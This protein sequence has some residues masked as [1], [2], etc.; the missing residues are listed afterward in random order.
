M[1]RE[2]HNE[3]PKTAAELMAEL[4][5][6]PQYVARM[7]AM[8]EERANAVEQRLRNAKPIVTDL[9]SAGFTVESVSD[10]FHL[11]MDYQKAIPI[12]L[13]WLPRLNDIA[14]KQDV[15]RALTV[16]WAKPTA[17]VPLIEEFRRA[18]G[19]S[20]E[21]LRWAIANALSVVA[22]DS[23]YG[24]VAQLAINPTNGKPREM[25][26]LALGNMENPQAVPVLTEL[27]K[28]DQVIGHAVMALGA[29]KAK[30]SRA[31]IQKHANHTKPWIRK[32][33]AAALAQIDD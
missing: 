16:L 31:E 11:K 22:D 30:S 25:L 7:K 3:L 14:V 20:N 29:L 15:I 6:D 24:D 4:S 2:F 13:A 28:D 33:V 23:V 10:L 32:E 9:V 5:K 26:T 27:L 21:S 17:A 1:P 19:P 8:R 18:V 12:L